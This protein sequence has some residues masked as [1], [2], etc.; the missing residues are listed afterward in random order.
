MH[1]EVSEQNYR[2]LNSH[3]NDLK[4]FKPLQYILNEAHFL[5]FT[6]KQNQAYQ[7][8]LNMLYDLIKIGIESK[9]EAII[10]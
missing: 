4:E 6:P 7:L 3:L 1:N 2:Q 5:G 9:V 10:F 8:Y